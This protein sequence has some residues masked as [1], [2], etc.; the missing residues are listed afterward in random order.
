MDQVYSVSGFLIGSAAAFVIA[1]LVIT[2]GWLGATRPARQTLRDAGRPGG[3]YRAVLLAHAHDP[4]DVAVTARAALYRARAGADDH[5]LTRLARRIGQIDDLVGDP[6]FRQAHDREAK[7]LPPGAPAQVAEV[8]SEIFTVP[9][10]A[11]CGIALQVWLPALLMAVL[12]DSMGGT[13][14]AGLPSWAA[15]GG[16]A[17][18]VAAAAGQTWLWRRAHRRWTRRFRTRAARIV[19]R[20]LG[21]ASEAFHADLHEGDLTLR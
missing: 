21:T 4:E 12:P 8:S 15:P 9:A 1:N 11:M 5:P 17:L 10:V 14:A 16:Y 20:E 3:F 7:R 13:D 18:F 2:V 6:D 19:R